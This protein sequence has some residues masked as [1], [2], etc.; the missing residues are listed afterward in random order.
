MTSILVMWSALTL[1]VI[2]S[3]S[4]CPLA[5]NVAAI[6]FLSRSLNNT[7]RVLL[8][9]L[10]YTLG[11]MFVYVGIGVLI[12]IFFQTSSPSEA[13]LVSNISRFLQSYMGIFLGPLL[14]LAGMFIL[15]MLQ[16][17]V[18]FSMNGQSLQR[19]F[20]DGG[21]IWSFPMGV[22]FALSFC[23]VSASLFFIG[24]LGLSTQYSSPVLLPT[25]FGIGT[26]LP[27]IIFALII[28]FAG[29][30]VG[31]AF[32]RLSQIERWVRIVTGMIFIGAGIYYILTHIYG[33]SLLI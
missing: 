17:S 31:K 15:G 24:L 1:G 14:I 29:K 19:R 6:S 20:Q 5:T 28:A 10:L 12:L 18:S 4:P 33:L 22:V 27:V 7:Q 32:N 13:T 21:I 9:G 16:T 8:S 26:A 3:I 2:T 25:L 23:P 11:R 30:M